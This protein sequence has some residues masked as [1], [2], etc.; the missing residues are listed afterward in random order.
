VET[1]EMKLKDIVDDSVLKFKSDK[2]MIRRKEIMALLEEAVKAND[3]EKVQLLQKRYAN[4]SVVLGL[5]SRK[6]GNR[7][8][9]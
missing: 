5:I 3:T 7:I 9:L 4:L 8:L 2:I 1:E 6:L